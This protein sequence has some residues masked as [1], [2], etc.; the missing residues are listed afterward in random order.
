MSPVVIMQNKYN[1]KCD[2]WSLGITAI[3][4]AEGEPPFSKTKAYLVLKKIISQPPK[5]LK[6]KDKWSKDFNDFIEKWLI[7]DPNE[8]PSAKELLKHSFIVK[9][10]KGNKLISELISELINNCFDD[11]VFYRKKIL[12]DSNYEEEEN[13]NSIIYKDNS[14]DFNPQNYNDNNGIMIN[15]EGC[16]TIINL[17]N[18][19]NYDFE[20]EKNEFNQSVNI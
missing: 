15:K 8:S 19:K 5:G 14:K 10:N 13:N 2:I 12:E 3:E 9:N 7:Y 11:L 20:E 16:N 17:E 1:Y 18:K 6:F 4:I